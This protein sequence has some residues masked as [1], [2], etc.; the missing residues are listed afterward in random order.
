MALGHA[1][2]LPG[3]GPITQAM[4]I[5]DDHA[6]G[7]AASP[8]LQAVPFQVSSVELAPNSLYGIAQ[9][10]NLAQ[11]TSLNTT[12]LTCIFTAAA[13]LTECDE[14]NCPSPGQEGM[15]K[16]NPVRGEMG[17]GG[18]YG[19]YLGHW[20]SATA[21]L[22]NNTGDAEVK[23][24]SEE[25]VRSLA[26][27][28]DAWETR[29]GADEGNGYLF[30][31]DP[32]VYRM[33]ETPPYRSYPIYSVPFYTTHKLLAGLLD[34]WQLARNEVAHQ[35]A[36]DLADWVVRNV[37]HTLVREG[38]AGWQ[39]ILGTEWGGMNEVMLN[40]YAATGNED[41]LT[42][43]YAFNHWAWSAP[44]AVGVDDL[45]GNHAN[46]HIPEVL[47]NAVGFELTGNATDEAIVLE[48]F[49]A[50]TQHHSWATGGSNS[51][52][53]WGEADRLGDELNSDTEESCTQYNMLKVARHLY[54]WTANS[55][56]FDFYE[57][58][59]FNG[60]LGNQNNLDA[61][62]TKFIY[63]LPL[64]G[65]GLHK[66]WGWSNSSI[67]CCWGS[68]SE[69]FS[70]MSDSIFFRSPD[71][72]QLF[73]NQFV[74]STVHWESRGVSISQAAGF[75]HSTSNTTVIKVS[76]R[77]S[78]W[79]MRIR[80][81]HWARGANEMTV[82]GEV[83]PAA[84]IVP[85]VYLNI[86]R[87]WRDG[88]EV[89][90][91]FPMDFWASHLNDDRD[92]YNGTFAFMYGPL[93]L[94]GLTEQNRFIPSGSAT[95]PSRW[96]RRSS[97]SKLSF[98]ASG[99]DAWSSAALSVP[100]IPLFEVMEETYSVYFDTNVPPV[101]PYS[102]QG[103]TMP[104]TKSQNLQTSGAASVSGGPRDGATSGGGNI[105]SG[106]PGETTRVTFAYGLQA[107][108]HML[109]SVSMSF[110]YL[111]G[112]SSGQTASTVDVLLVDAA[113]QDVVLKTLLSTEPLGDYSFDHFVGYSPPISVNAT[114]L[115]LANDSPVLLVM[116]FHNN[117]RNLQ[118]PIDDLAAGFD[119]QIRWTSGDLKQLVV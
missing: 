43:G 41:Y 59:I 13:N 54:E 81:P 33:L 2:T 24:M 96:I 66:P 31:Y 90:V 23:R 89:Q 30:P 10:R 48:F 53:H 14:S 45:A 94:A 98:E 9:A 110:R 5:V 8:K 37:N 79:A 78:R 73:V 93:V 36:L 57:T 95:D 77:A 28:Q 103:A 64:G 72:S 105:R 1:N 7:C 15:P 38:M 21:Y 85:G 3:L 62:M 88:D 70:K 115:G 4:V 63:M 112:Y 86:E 52:E 92:E 104:S 16:C 113:R 100:M 80:V 117:D 17:L 60:I 65:S 50:V 114:G 68:L 44:L 25:V 26:S 119:I 47:G 75:P 32:I 67:P 29:Y 34:Q 40:M 74:S 18:Y 106:D 71:D 42:A 116:E 11:L 97:D 76:G 58:A 69:Q 107:P 56:L 87:E 12:E 27:C 108:G 109:D 20:L 61:D 82:A 35:A 99:R 91:Y 102:P 19:H 101:L 111:A 83:I 46:T 6:K 55:S 22:V 39:R 51:G 49:N 84:W 118:I